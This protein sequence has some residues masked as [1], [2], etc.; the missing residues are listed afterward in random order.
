MFGEDSLDLI[1]AGL[2][3][4]MKDGGIL[5]LKSSYTV[6]TLFLH[7]PRL[8][9]YNSRFLNLCSEMDGRVRPLVYTVRCWAQHNG[10]SGEDG[11]REKKK[12]AQ[13]PG[14]THTSS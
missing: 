1:L 5:G 2:K 9:L 8:A 10:L 4:V 3:S 12:W 7:C 6:T 13:E 14:L 11:D